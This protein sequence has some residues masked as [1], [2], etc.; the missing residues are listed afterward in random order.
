MLANSKK[1]K[2]IA[3]RSIEKNE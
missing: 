2:N 3:K 1:Q